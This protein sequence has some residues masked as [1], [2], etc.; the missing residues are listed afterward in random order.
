MGL[1]EVL[2]FADALVFAKTGRHL[3]DLERAIFQGSWQGQKYGEIANIYHCTEGH[4][5]DVGSQLWKS[6]S[7]TLGVA[8]SKKHLRWPIEMALN[9]QKIQ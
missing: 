1:E 9:Q 4:V 6:I 5:K 7:T 3:T 2:D 8:V